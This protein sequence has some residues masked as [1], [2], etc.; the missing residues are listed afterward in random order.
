MSSFEKYV[1][2]GGLGFQD[3][4]QA[5]NSDQLVEPHE[6]PP[7]RLDS[8]LQVR[9]AA[10]LTLD[11]S[12][13]ATK[14]PGYEIVYKNL[15][16]TI[17]E[18]LERLE[19]LRTIESL[20]IDA[21]LTELEHVQKLFKAPLN[22]HSNRPDL[23]MWEESPRESVHYGCVLRELYL[24]VLAYMEEYASKCSQQERMY[25]V[26]ALSAHIKK[27][28]KYEP[29]DLDSASEI[30]STM[31]NIGGD[32]GLPKVGETITDLRHSSME[33]VSLPM[34][35]SVEHTASHR[36]SQ[37]WGYM[38]DYDILAYD[39]SNEYQ[40]FYK[41]LALDIAAHGDNNPALAVQTL[42]PLLAYESEGCLHTYLQAF[43]RL[44]IQ[45]SAPYLLESVKSDD[46]LQRR[47]SAELLYH[48]EVARVGIT[49]TKGVE[50]FGK[51]YHLMC[52]ADPN[53]FRNLVA[54]EGA[55]V[56]RIDNQGSIGV[57][58]P[59]GTLLS[60]FQLDLETDTKLVE[61]L[62]QEI[63]SGDVFLP[64]ADETTEQR[65]IREAFLQTFLAGYGATSEQIGVRTSIYLNSL[66]L[67]EQ[68]WFIMYY[69]NAEVEEQARLEDFIR[70][71]G[72][73][74]LKVFLALDYGKTGDA[75]LNYLDESATPEQDK[76]ALLLHFSQIANRAL[77]WRMFF[78]GITAEMA[79]SRPMG[80][81]LNAG[82]SR[83]MDMAKV[84]MG[85]P[86]DNT[87]LLRGDTF[88]YNFAA[89]LHEALIRKNV[90]FIQAALAI[91]RG[92]GGDVT[93]N[94]LLE[95]MRAIA[96][97]MHVVT[98][99][100]KDDST[101]KLEEDG[102][103][104]TP[105]YA[106]VTQT[107]LIEDART[108]WI[109]SDSQTNDRV[110][111]TIRPRATVGVGEYTGGEARIQFRVKNAGGDEVRISFDQSTLEISQP[112]RPPQAS[113]DFG[114]TLARHPDV[115][116]SGDAPTVSNISRHTP[117]SANRYASASV[118]RVLSLAEGSEGGH[119]EGSFSPRAVTQFE[120]LANSVL[121]YLF[122]KYGD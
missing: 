20:S 74:G 98:G 3:G 22:S 108:T 79:I 7:L 39:D 96:Y 73:L 71:Y 55:Y 121:D 112:D 61:A 57:F 44:G 4:T 43:E 40:R 56:E 15:Q 18:T 115:A 53:F 111:I 75:L 60:R 16:S 52:E 82:V 31:M 66:A 11:A 9:V 94:E 85:E 28:I 70:S 32:A 36:E 95:T 83:H 35:A 62:T 114:V 58:D 14:R 65:K 91:E 54:V 33:S 48:M 12:Y 104:V 109:L 38:P 101:L 80:L 2:A 118:G 81:G 64:K 42:I 78:E 110:T 8:A 34:Q 41:R 69:S 1:N 113:L 10:H 47:I 24:P 97:A 23:S 103:R 100:Y 102:I 26:D 119:N 6:T 122:E 29:Y 120:P 50:Y 68:G 105:E 86:L 30:F 37:M 17:T 25:I 76:K 67:H 89:D 27:T 45:Y 99:L 19:A 49:S 51:V 46:V 106:D 84:A 88:D 107:E 59:K 5:F 87:A 63:T 77:E 21:Y 72:E 90:E 117:I 13:D 92:D 93:M 116:A